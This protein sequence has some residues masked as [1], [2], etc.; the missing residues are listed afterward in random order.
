MQENSIVR[1]T[2]QSSQ[3]TIVPQPNGSFF[4]VG[5][6]LYVTLRFAHQ[7][8]RRW[9]RDLHEYVAQGVRENSE[10]LDEPSRNVS[11]IAQRE[12]DPIWSA[13]PLL[14]SV[15]VYFGYTLVQTSHC[16]QTKCFRPMPVSA[17]FK[18]VWRCLV[19]IIAIHHP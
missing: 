2:V 1:K 4:S 5:K 6:N 16:R 10:I 18:N 11:K 14:T 9:K 3:A 8:E 12:G 7:K 13:K 19:A 15:H 17:V